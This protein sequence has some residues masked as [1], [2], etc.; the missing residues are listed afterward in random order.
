MKKIKKGIKNNNAKAIR[1]SGFEFFP[2]GVV[3]S[4][5][6]KMIF[7]LEHAD[8]KINSGDEL[9]VEKMIAIVDKYPTY[10]WA[11]ANSMFAF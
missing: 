8:A 3:V 11:K 4:H 10:K 5:T 7:F 2:E 1:S 6:E 9:F